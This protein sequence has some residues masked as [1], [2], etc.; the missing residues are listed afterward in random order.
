MEDRMS[1]RI[2]G[3]ITLL[4][5][6]GAIIV[7]ILHPRPP[8]GTE[9]LLQIVASMPHWTIL[10][11]FAVFPA[12]FIVSGFALLVRTLRDPAARAIGE[13]GKYTTMGGVAVFLAAIIV[14][15][16]GY[17]YYA[18]RWMAASGEEKS[19][20]LF[21]ANA[22]HTIDLALFLVWVGL[23]MG[24]GILLIAVALLCSKE[25][26]RVFAVLGLIG[27]SMSF[28]YAWLRVFKVTS[29]LPLWPL[30]AALNALWITA[31]GVYMLKKSIADRRV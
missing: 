14:D 26:S 20:I 24:L 3:I 21:A 7:N 5:G 4:G 10:H 23:F 31:L 6:I 22:V 30:G 16:Y 17:P 19:L 8:D 13:V 28:A 9:A 25:F 1:L 15:G 18:H 12:V 27:A 11:F 29:A 2:G